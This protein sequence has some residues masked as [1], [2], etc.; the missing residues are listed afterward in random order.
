V[1]TNWRA[2][3]ADKSPVLLFAGKFGLLVLLLYGLLMIPFTERIL[4]IYLEINASAS[5]L[6]LNAFGQGTHVTEV[7][8]QSPAFAIAIRRGCDAIE[9]TWLLC[10]AMLAFPSSLYSKLAG[11]AAGILLLQFLN[12]IRI[13]TLYMIGCH[14]PALFTSAHLEIWP[15]AFVM[16]AIM[17]FISW[18][19]W[20]NVR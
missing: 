18:K 16:A 20:A 3:F 17:I 11:V 1:T 4:Y 9:P 15:T 13:V 10:A 8:I 2:W 12:L 7:T 19:G 6:I 5:N 14:Y